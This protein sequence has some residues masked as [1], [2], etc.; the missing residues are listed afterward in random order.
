MVAIDMGSSGI[1]A[2]AA[3]P[4]EDGIL[5]ILGMESIAKYGPV[6]KGIVAQSTEVSGLINRVLLCL[7]NRLGLAEPIGSCFVTVGGELLQVVP[8]PVKRN[9]IT[10]SYITDSLL[11][12]MRTEVVTKIEEKYP[13]MKVVSAEPA[14]Y[15]LDGTEQTEAPAG[16]QKAKEIQV[17]YS[18]FVAKLEAVD[19]LVGAFN[20][21]GRAIGFQW[22]RP[23]AQMV[24]LMDDTDH[25]QGRA[26]VD[27]GAQTTTLSICR[28][29]RCLF[30]KVFPLGGYHITRDIQSQQVSFATAE[31]AKTLFGV[32]AEQYLKETR[33]LRMA[34][35]N[36]QAEP[37]TVST[38]LLA[39]IINSRLKEIIMPVMAELK[40]HESEV[41]GVYLTGGAS[42]LS[43]LVPFV[44]QFTSLPVGYGSHA[45]WLDRTAEDEYYKPEYSCLVGTLALAAEYRKNT[46]D[47]LNDP[48]F[49][50]T[51]GKGG[52]INN[53]KKKLQDK[54]LDLF[55]DN[56]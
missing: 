24:A 2:M 56:T 50:S 21:S 23:E 54:T 22:A 30:T 41:A 42:L 34:S 40:K 43:G 25:Q 47:N 33:M 27:F 44:Q 39:M 11:K 28:E 19:K 48:P 20:R 6:V 55:T 14:C 17:R 37:V 35:V 26:I 10:K 38:S 45:D 53:I 16:T 32:A 49:P 4:N 31:K 7:Q 8:V 15:I 36:P 5:H 18:V 9:L 46:D 52:W 12:E 29:D 3:L 51:G 13:Q 1:R